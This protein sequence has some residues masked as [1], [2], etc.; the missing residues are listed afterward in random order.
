M[1]KSRSFSCVSL[2]PRSASRVLRTERARTVRTLLTERVRHRTPLSHLRRAFERHARERAPHTSRPFSANP[3]T[4]DPALRSSSHAMPAVSKA[5]AGA[6]KRAAAAPAIVEDPSMLVACPVITAHPNGFVERTEPERETHEVR[7]V[8][9]RQRHIARLG[10]ARAAAR[11]PRGVSRHAARRPHVQCSPV[12]ARARGSPRTRRYAA[13]A[14]RA[15]PHSPDRTV[16]PDPRAWSS[17]RRRPPRTE[18]PYGKKLTVRH[19]PTRFSPQRV[20][21]RQEE[22]FVQPG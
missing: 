3:W 14:D 6:P 12:D 4:T 17:P 18:C 10:R 8:P 7:C 16:S 13:R 19:A 9:S 22:A 15:S 1:M 21:A 5:G 11:G 20:Q 2:A